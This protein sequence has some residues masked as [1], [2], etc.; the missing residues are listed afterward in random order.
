MSMDNGNSVATKHYSG[1]RRQQCNGKVTIS[2]RAK[3]SLHSIESQVGKAKCG[4]DVSVW[5]AT[6][7]KNFGCLADGEAALPPSKRLHRALEAMSTNVAED[8]PISPGGPSALKMIVNGSISQKG[9]EES[10]VQKSNSPSNGVCGNLAPPVEQMRQ[11]MRSIPAVNL[12]ELVAAQHKRRWK[13][14]T[15]K[16]S[17]LKDGSKK[18]PSEDVFEMHSDPISSNREN[19]AVLHD[20]NL[21]QSSPQKSCNDNAI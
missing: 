15:F 6:K 11:L 18:D 13:L 1:T 7:N 14:L 4:W 20:T 19:G 10:V 17:E 9:T 21:L 16:T 2:Q 8:E 3:S 12:L 5:E